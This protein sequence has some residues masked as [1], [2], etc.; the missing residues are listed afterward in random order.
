L[1][2]FQRRQQ[3]LKIVQDEPGLRVPQLADLLS[4]SQGTIRNDLNALES[5]GQLMR[6]RGG[7]VVIQ[8]HTPGSPAFATRARL[9]S[10][11]KDII[12]RFAANQVGDGDSLLLDASTTVYAMARHLQERQGLRIITNGIEVARLLASNH[13]NTVILLGGVLRPDGAS[14]TGSLSERF[15]RDLHI[16]SAYVSCSGFTLNAGLTEVDIHEAQLKEIAIRSAGKVIALVDSSKFGKAD[17]TPF[18]R[19]DQIN[20]LFVDYSLSA[21]WLLLL[22]EAGLNF[23]ICQ[24][25]KGESHVTAS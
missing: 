11:T 20:H 4:V 10:E 17:L 2:T 16:G 6:V 12:A 25:V 21:D 19:L 14:I 13:S 24:N 8:D 23:T 7:A 18:A 3:L 15:L 9:N 1:T 5:A 22:E